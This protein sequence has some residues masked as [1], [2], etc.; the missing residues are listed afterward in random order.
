MNGSRTDGRRLWKE[1]VAVWLGLLILLAAS[2]ASAYAPLGALNTAL[3]LLIG[4]AMV[5]LLVIVLMDL[6]RSSVL[7]HLLAGAG[8]FWT[9]F[10]FAL[11]WVDY[12]T[13]HY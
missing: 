1:P 6:R 8:L 10:M 11:T 12:A 5:V 7:V 9:I 4:A 13:R 3:N 2:T